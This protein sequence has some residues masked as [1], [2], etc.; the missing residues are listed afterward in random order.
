MQ[1]PKDG[2]ECRVLYVPHVTTVAEGIVQCVMGGFETVSNAVVRH[3]VA[4]V[5]VLSLQGKHL[6]C[7]L[8]LVVPTFC[9]RIKVRW[10]PH[11]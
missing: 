7:S 8:S 2:I 9:S 1:K 6:I 4:D 11:R 3:V 10:T 5:I